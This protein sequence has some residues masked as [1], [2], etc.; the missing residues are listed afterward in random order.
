LDPKNIAFDVVLYFFNKHLYQQGNSFFNIKFMTRCGLISVLGQANAGKSTLINALTG[1]K[2][3]IVSEKPHTTRYEIYG[4]VCHEESQMIFVD[5]PGLIERPQGPL[6][7]FMAKT[8]SRSLRDADI[9]MIIIDIAC[10][11]P[12]STHQLLNR[13][14]DKPLII[15]FNKID[16][17]SKEK[18]LPLAE[19]YRQWTPYIAMTSA[20]KGTGLSYLFDTIEKLI[21]E[22]HWL[23]DKEDLTQIT[24][25]FWAAEMTREKIF[26]CVHQEIPYHLHVTTDEWTETPKKLLLR[27]TIIVDQDKYKKW[28]IGYQGQRIKLIGQKSRF[29]LAHHLNKEVHLFLSVKVNPQWAVQLKMES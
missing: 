21:P 4:I 6:Q 3:S 13:L 25:R 10:P 11:I 5:T 9:F 7:S 15:V 29:E 16:K 12:E 20:K 1:E 26:A 19:K 18:L 28:V 27:Q 14:K 8:T 23:F 17:I 24:Q 2:V 22:G